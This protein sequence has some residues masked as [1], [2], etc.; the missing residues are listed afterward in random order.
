MRDA[1]L[2]DAGMSSTP[3]LNHD[4]LRIAMALLHGLLPFQIVTLQ[5]VLTK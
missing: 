1:T 2:A 4:S 3:F 5:G